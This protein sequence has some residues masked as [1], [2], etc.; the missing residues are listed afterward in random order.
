MVPG[1]DTNEP[2]TITHRARINELALGA[3]LPTVYPFRE[4]V[5]SGGLMSYGPNFLDR[6]RRAG[7]QRCARYSNMSHGASF[8]TPPRAGLWG[9]RLRVLYF[10][11]AR[12]RIFQSCPKDE[13][14]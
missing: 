7:W 3:K 8:R 4:F 2:L 12:L 6:F 13:C 10:A 5:D 14:C 9:T 11:V 1:A